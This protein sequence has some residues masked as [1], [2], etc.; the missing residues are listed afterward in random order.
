MNQNVLFR[1]VNLFEPSLNAPGGHILF[2]ARQ[3]PVGE[4]VY[5]SDLK[6]YQ[7]TAVLEFLPGHPRGNHAH[8][9]RTEMFYVIEGQ[10]TAHFWTQEKSNNPTEVVLKKGDW[11]TVYPHTFH[12]YEAIE[13]TLILELSHQ[14][15][16]SND[17]V[18]FNA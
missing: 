6:G 2:G 12:R 18:G 16:D 3:T 4:S 5:L 13:R 17:S 11:V 10:M 1:V 7:F 9:Q 15:Y 8:H 14:A